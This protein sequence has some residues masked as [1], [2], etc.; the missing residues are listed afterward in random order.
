MNKCIMP[1][2]SGVPAN[3]ILVLKDWKPNDVIEVVGI[4]LLEGTVNRKIKYFIIK[5]EYLNKW[6]L[7]IPFYQNYKYLVKYNREVFAATFY[8]DNLK[9]P[10]IVKF[11]K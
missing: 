6:V 11:T 1:I 2:L 4:N 5:S 8:Q 9:F 10:K 3:G 7:H